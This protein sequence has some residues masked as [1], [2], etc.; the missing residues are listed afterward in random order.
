MN[1][2][3]D[4]YAADKLFMVLSQFYNWVS[5]H[6]PETIAEMPFALQ[7]TVAWVL[8]ELSLEEFDL[9]DDSILHH[10]EMAL[11]E[12][13]ER[14]IVMDCRTCQARHAVNHFRHVR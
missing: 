9:F 12:H 3:N 4:Q 7:S 2:R 10:V 14:C 13:T 8:G 1:L 5:N 11:D 6:S